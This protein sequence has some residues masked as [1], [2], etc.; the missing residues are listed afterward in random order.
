VFV[1][2]AR[3]FKDESKIK[4]P[5]AGLAISPGKTFTV[6]DGPFTSE[7]SEPE[8]V[9]F[10][11]VQTESGKQGF[12]TEGGLAADKDDKRYYIEPAK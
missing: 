10:Y 5:A 12:I 11:E 7:D 4:P 9:C 1:R 8:K 6:L 2:T 3:N